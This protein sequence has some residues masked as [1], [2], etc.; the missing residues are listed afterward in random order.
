MNHICYPIELIRTPVPYSRQEEKQEQKQIGGDTESNY[1][2]VNVNRQ[3]FSSPP[4]YSFSSYSLSSSSSL[5]L[6]STKHSSNQNHQI[7]NNNH[8]NHHHHQQQQQLQ[9]QQQPPP[10]P[11]SSK[12]NY[13]INVNRNNKN[14]NDDDAIGKMLNDIEFGGLTN[15]VTYVSKDEHESFLSKETKK[16]LMDFRKTAQSFLEKVPFNTVPSSHYYFQDVYIYIYSI[17]LYYYYL[18]CLIV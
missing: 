17:L 10:L 11:S 15:F 1:E 7:Q 14:N 6:P 2:P 3:L 12:N 16:K 8:H 5:P 9:Q 18:F 13:C 4:P